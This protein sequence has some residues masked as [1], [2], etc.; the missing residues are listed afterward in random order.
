MNNAHFIDLFIANLQIDP[1]EC[2]EN[3]SRLD[4]AEL[5]DIFYQACVISFE[6]TNLE[7][8]EDD[9]EYL[10]S[11]YQELYD[12]VC[13]SLTDDLTIST[14]DPSSLTKPAFLPRIEHIAL[15]ED[16][17]NHQLISSGDDLPHTTFGLLL[18]SVITRHLQVA[19]ESDPAI[20]RLV[21]AG[22]DRLMH[23][24]LCGYLRL[25]ALSP[26]VFAGLSIKWYVIPVEENS[27]AAFI[28][29]HDAWYK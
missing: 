9:T 27:V 28:A 23:S 24:I 5:P 17:N 7:G 11:K 13:D 16:L 1:A 25:K 15:L 19:D 10:R 20:L 3:M 12:K 6:G 21:I 26:E 18:E 29:R 22:S 4:T 8:K 2:A 14:G